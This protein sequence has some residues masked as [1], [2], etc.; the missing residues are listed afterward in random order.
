MVSCFLVLTFIGKLRANHQI[1]HRINRFQYSF[2]RLTLPSIHHIEILEQ[3]AIC[4]TNCGVGFVSLHH[5]NS[6]CKVMSAGIKQSQFSLQPQT[7]TATR[8]NY[9]LQLQ[10]NVFHEDHFDKNHLYLK[11]NERSVF[12]FSGS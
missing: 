8:V 5:G 11:L 9:S 2:T 1:E 12:S 7:C 4:C 3:G 10:L 6:S